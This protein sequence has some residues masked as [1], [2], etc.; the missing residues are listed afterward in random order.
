M[1]APPRGV[2]PKKEAPPASARGTAT[3]HTDHHPTR[4][5]REDGFAAPTAEDRAVAA[6]VAVLRDH[7]YGIACRCLDCNRPITSAASLARMRGPWC[8]QRAGV[9]I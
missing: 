8:A 7:G 3:T 9:T 2:P 5:R 6:A 1:T 4:H